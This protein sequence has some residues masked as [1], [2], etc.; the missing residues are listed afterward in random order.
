MKQQLSEDLRRFFYRHL[1]SLGWTDCAIDDQGKQVGDLRAFS[2][3]G[4]IMS[5]G[6]E[7]GLVTA[8]HILDDI[9]SNLQKGRCR[10]VNSVLLDA[11]SEG[12]R[13]AEPIPFML[14]DAMKTSFWRYEPSLGLDFGV[15]GISPMYRKLLE[16][17]RVRPFP[18]EHWESQIRTGFDFFYQ[19]G[20]PSEAVRKVV[21]GA[22]D[23]QRIKSWVTP[24]M[25]PVQWIA[26]PPE[27]LGGKKFPCF[28]GQ[29]SDAEVSN[30]DGM[31]GGPILGFWMEPDG[32]L[33][34]SVVAIQSGWD[35]ATRCTW[36]CFIPVF[37]LYLDAAIEHLRAAGH[38]LGK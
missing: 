21:A 32:T 30:M 29:V 5:F 14:A 9:Y 6:D 38:D 24:A 22:G 3:S 33:R 16:A 11:W 8:G 34:Y 2:V 28:Y 10:I 17:N 35:S 7:W 27:K 20:V 4:F 1:V 26:D 19:L 12:A 15:I 37:L 25:I 23:R 13:S 36:G 31:S 18:T